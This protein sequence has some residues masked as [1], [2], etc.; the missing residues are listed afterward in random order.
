MFGDARQL[1]PYEMIRPTEEEIVQ[2]RRSLSLHKSQAGTSPNLNGGY[3]G[4]EI[5]EL[6]L[7][8]SPSDS[9]ILDLFNEHG[10]ARPLPKIDTSGLQVHASLDVSLSSSSSA[11]AIAPW[12][13]SPGPDS[14]AS[15]SFEWEISSPNSAMLRRRE[16]AAREGA[17]GIF[18]PMQ[19]ALSPIVSRAQW[20]IVMRS[21]IIGV[22]V[23]LIVCGICAAPYPGT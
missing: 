2:T 5:H 14:T 17:K 18:A 11:G 7:K 16:V 10:D 13:A 3:N 22:I 20:I 4:T 21:A 8:P 19:E 23:G 9:S 1:H 6:M 12:L 15:T